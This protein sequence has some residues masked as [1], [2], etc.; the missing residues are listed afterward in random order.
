MPTIWEGIALSFVLLNTRPK[1]IE[2]IAKRR[3]FNL[4]YRKTLDEGSSDLSLEM[5]ENLYDLAFTMCLSKP[6]L[7]KILVEKKEESKDD[8]P[9]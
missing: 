2:E 1:Q 9:A 4:K 5:D 6:E 8:N 3:I 7:I